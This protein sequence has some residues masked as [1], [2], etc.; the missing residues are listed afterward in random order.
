MSH[1]P[2]IWE[3]R[4][5]NRHGSGDL[6]LLGVG[7][8]IEIMCLVMDFGEGGAKH[9]AHTAPP[10]VWALHHHYCRLPG[11]FSAPLPS[12][13]EF[14][15][16]DWEPREE[17]Q[18]GSCSLAE[19]A[20]N[21]VEGFLFTGDTKKKKH[22]GGSSGLWVEPLFLI[23][24]FLIFWDWVP[25]CGTHLVLLRIS[26]H[27]HGACLSRAKNSSSY[28]PLLELAEGFQ[29]KSLCIF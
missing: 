17:K 22:H 28:Y 12:G 18:A 29:M 7:Y 2:A 9:M 25:S 10:A 20:G 15:G 3:I 13:G 14:C 24:S 16:S 1:W 4:I 11:E 19:F 8:V 23:F 5:H 21:G 26:M 27:D 6:A